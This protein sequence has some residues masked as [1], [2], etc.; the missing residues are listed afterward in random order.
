MT[1]QVYVNKIELVGRV[2]QNPETRYFES[3]AV[4]C[5]LT[6]A[7]KPP[8][9]S[10]TPLWFDLEA[11]GNIAEV[12]TQYVKKGSTI[13][14]T[15]ELVLDKWID[16]NTEELREKPLIRVNNLELISS[17]RSSEEIESNSDQQNQILNANF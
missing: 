15:G 17:S 14:I 1:Q 8:Y 16:K 11:W 5:T 4:K 10:D 13:G 9:K 6:L 7:I 12:A 2:G 3:G